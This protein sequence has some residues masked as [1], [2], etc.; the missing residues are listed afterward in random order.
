ML[1]TT[2]FGNFCLGPSDQLNGLN[3]TLDFGHGASGRN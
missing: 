1:F 2:R 3:S